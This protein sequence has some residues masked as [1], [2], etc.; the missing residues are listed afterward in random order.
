MCSVIVIKGLFKTNNDVMA[1]L[2]MGHVMGEC[3]IMIHDVASH[4]NIKW[5]F[6]H[7]AFL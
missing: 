5:G 7:A 2:G 6:N 3:I 4:N 1:L